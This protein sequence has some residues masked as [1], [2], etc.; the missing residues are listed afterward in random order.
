MASGDNQTGRC[1]RL[2]IWILPEENLVP[3]GDLDAAL[4]EMQG[5]TTH[6]RINLLAFSVEQYCQIMGHYPS[7]LDELFALSLPDTVASQCRPNPNYRVDAWEHPFVY[8]IE[9]GLPTVIS[10]GVDGE[11]GTED[12]IVS[13]RPGMV[14]ARAIDMRVDC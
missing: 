7:S 5:R 2:G 13:A 6:A 14:G 3:S 4:I 9:N 10:S 11:F 1:G 12:D 8:E